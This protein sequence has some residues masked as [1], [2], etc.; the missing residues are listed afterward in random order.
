MNAQ[1]QKGGPSGALYS[2]SE[3]GWITEELFLEYLHRFQKHVKPSRED[4]VLL[5][6][7]SHATHATLKVFNF[8]KLNGISVVTMPPHT[9][10]RL[11]SLDVTFYSPLK[12]AFNNEHSKYLRNHPLSKITPYELAELFNNAYMKV[13]TPEKTIKGFQ[14]T[15]IHPYNLTYFLEKILPR[16]TSVKFKHKMK[17]WRKALQYNH[18]AGPLSQSRTNRQLHSRISYNYL[19]LPKSR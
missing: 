10:H 7:D 2:C 14:T 17:C 6:M 4:P 1:L 8:W 3:K 13:A 15:G 16:L 5:I 18:E 12:S 9:S 19:V 11:Q